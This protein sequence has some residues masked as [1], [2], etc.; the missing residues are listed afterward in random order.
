MRALHVRK[1]ILFPSLLIFDSWLVR[2]R[3]LS[4][5]TILLQNCEG[6]A[7]LSSSFQYCFWEIW[8]HSDPCSIIYKVFSFLEI[9][10]VSFGVLIFQDEV[11][12]S[13]SFISHYSESSIGPVNVKFKSLWELFLCLLWNVLPCIFPIFFL[14]FL[15]FHYWTSWNNPI[16]FFFTPSVLLFDFLFY[17]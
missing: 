17:F 11:F 16:S 13:R 7:P 6:I 3:I 15:F 9:S 5:K 4:W 14:E 1:L 8:C 2:Y 10:R 12:W